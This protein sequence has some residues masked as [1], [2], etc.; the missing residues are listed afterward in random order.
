[1]KKFYI[2]LLTA[3]TISFAQTNTSFEAKEGYEL[4]NIHTQNNWEVADAN[5]EIL[6][7]Q[8]VS[9]EQAS[10]GIY[11]FKNG[12]QPDFGPKWLPVMGVTKTF[13][14]PIDYKGFTISF[15]AFVTKRNGADFEFNLYTI[16]PDTDEFYPVAG[17]GMENRGYLYI[18][19]D[20]NYGFD[21]ADAA[22][23]WSINKWN[24]FKIEVTENEIK[25]YLNDQLVYTGDNFTKLD[26]HGFTMLHNNYGGDAYYDNFKFST[27]DL[28][29]HQIEGKEFKIYP[30]PVKDYLTFDANFHEQ[31]SSVEVSN[32][33]GQVVL[34]SN[35]SLK[36]LDTSSL[37]SGVYFVK[38][39]LKD[40]K[41][42]TRKIIKK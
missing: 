17:L 27:D 7:N 39:N 15:D 22:E 40:G 12:D 20:I 37:K 33:I 29:V 34:K 30:N 42:I 10:D 4:G 18:T 8:L 31:I 26:V 38:I 28:A 1:M 9:D 23:G 11:S 14:K 5:G 36:G 6:N 13:E 21:Y 19:K 41:T 25:Y 2:L 32:T 3:S 16:N 24:N 35:Q